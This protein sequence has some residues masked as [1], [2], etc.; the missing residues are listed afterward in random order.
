MFETESLSVPRAGWNTVQ[1]LY[2]RNHILCLVAAANLTLTI[3]FTVLMALDGR[4]LLGRNVWTKPWKFAISIAIFAGTMGWILPS[5]SLDNRIERAV[6]LIIGSA[7][8]IEIVLISM[9]AARGVASHFNDSTPMDTAIYAVMG[10]TITISSIAV[11][12]VLWRFVRNPPSLAPAYLWGL[13]LGMFLFVVAS[14]EGW[15]MVAYSGHGIGVENATAGL[16]LL[17]WNLTSGDLRVAHFVGL[18]ALQ[19]LPLVGYGAAT[20]ER[21]STHQSIWIVGAGSLLYGSV[22]ILAFLQA[23]LGH[24]VVREGLS[25]SL[26]P[27]FLAGCFVIITVGSTLG[28]AT[29]WHQSHQHHSVRSSDL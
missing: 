24:P 18:H 20:W 4:T 2:R 23:I 13:R 1:E 17:N 15:V 26:S 19:I 6:S 11:A 10:V 12:Y 3:V 14:I 8:T 29:R 9:Q 16:P 25:V 5:L 7:M 28:L 21:L 27:S 22:T